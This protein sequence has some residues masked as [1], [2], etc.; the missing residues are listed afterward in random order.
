ME[1][2]K[3]LELGLTRRLLT[4]AKQNPYRVV[5]ERKFLDKPFCRAFCDWCAEESFNFP[6]EAVS[7]ALLAVELAN[8]IDDSHLSCRALGLLA[9]A[10]FIASHH[11]DAN[12]LL[13]DAEE[14]ANEC[15]CCL[16]EVFRRRG[17]F[18]QH[19]GEMAEALS[20]LD[21]AA[22]ECQKIQD[23]DGIGR[24][25]V[26]RG[27]SLKHLGRDDEALSSQRRALILLSPSSPKI[28]HL[29]ALVNIGYITATGENYQFAL[30]AQH[31]NEF[32]AHLRGVTG[33]TRIR[34]SL[35]WIDGLVHAR[36]K[37]RKKALQMLRK[38][39]KA[40]IRLREDQDA[41]AITADIA[42]LY[43]ETSRFRLIIDIITDTLDSLGDVSGT[44]QL[45]QK[46][47]YFARREAQ[48]TQAYIMEL[49]SA[50]D[51][52]MPFLLGEPSS[53]D[54]SSPS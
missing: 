54:F 11:T 34:I 38:A 51:A 45:L 47:L 41:I 14:I 13:D 18:L 22:A 16:S 3:D 5:V 10:H 50:V 39:R 49:R 46:I 19:K 48:V 53:A 44:R 40:L 43:S 9:S 8:K 25:E 6:K 33:F 37:E 24:V 27:V 21:M 29:A 2:T 26:N 42:K 30:A 28:F 4:K 17:V 52:H 31:L 23:M 36:L 15:S 1:Q 12:Q 7:R 20:L 32:R 35:S